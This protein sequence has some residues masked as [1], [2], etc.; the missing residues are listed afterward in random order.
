MRHDARAPNSK[1]K[2]DLVLQGL[3]RILD[4]PL[5][6]EAQSLSIGQ[7]HDDQA[8]HPHTILWALVPLEAAIGHVGCSLP[9]VVPKSRSPKN[10]VFLGVEVGSRI[11]PMVATG[12]VLEH[13]DD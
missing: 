1:R 3:V 5:I 4:P 13:F 8:C 9:P 10:V 7:V 6:K 2:R 11:L 12:L